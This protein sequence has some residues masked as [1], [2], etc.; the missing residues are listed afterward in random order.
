MAEQTTPAPAAK[1]KRYRLT[2]P[3]QMDGAVRGRG[4]EFT[5][6]EGQMGP[7]RAVRVT[8]DHIDYDPANGIDANHVPG[9]MKDEPLYEEV[10]DE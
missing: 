6:A 10:K 3:A 5:L 9:E 1:P 4:H 8:H 7:H 2:A